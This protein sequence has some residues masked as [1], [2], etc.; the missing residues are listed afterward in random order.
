[1]VATSAPPADGIDQAAAR[2]AED[3]RRRPKFARND[4]F[5]NDVRRRVEDYFRHSGRRQRDVPAMYLKTA[6]ILALLAASYALL[7]FAAQAWWQA[8]PLAI[9]LGLS[10]A[11]VGF[12][13]QHDGSHQGYSDRPW[14]NKMMALTL[15]LVGG[16]SYLWHWKHNVIH[17]TYVNIT[18]HD[19]DVDLGFLGRLTPHQR[20][21][22]W[23]RFQRW[24]LWPLY[25]VMSIKWQLLD[26]FQVLITGRQGKDRV[27]R[28][29]RWDLVAFVIGKVVFFTLAFGVPLLL[30]P[31]WAVLLFYGITSC[32][33][34]IT[35][36]IVFQMA[37]CVEQAE[38]PLPQP[39]TGR[40][41]KSWA[42][43]QVET[44][45]DFA[46]HSRVASWL[47]GGLNFQIEHHL[48]PRIC[49]VN[50]PA[51]S[52]IV[53]ETCREH[54]VKYAVHAS[55][56]AGLAAHYRWLRRLG[57]P[58]AEERANLG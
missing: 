15:D 18:G 10:M 50:Y 14:V 9:L 19:N 24:Y 30:H 11:G 34:G 36:S 41:E 39:E 47:L 12:N 5:H 37:H 54:G 28:P 27:P 31:W 7:V 8:V 55:F 32:V 42:V 57:R 33:L 46:R 38:F 52:K 53:E 2:T 23:H 49:H 51:I 17:H 6:I 21:L 4:G 29:K 44:T 1:M 35:L 16:S 48:F 3:L 22:P 13:V 40:I 43:H 25:G 26:D 45:V 56:W 20:W 58:P